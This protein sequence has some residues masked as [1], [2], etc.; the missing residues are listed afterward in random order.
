MSS[1]DYIRIFAEDSKE[2]LSN[3]T[4]AA[5]KSFLNKFKKWFT[6]TVGKEFSPQNINSKHIQEY[7]SRT[8]ET[9]E[10]PQ[11]AQRTLSAL[12]A[13][14][15]WAL[16]KGYVSRNPT[17]DIKNIHRKKNTPQWLTKEELA[18][19]QCALETKTADSL[20]NRVLITLI[21]NT[22][23]RISEAVE[24]KISDVVIEKNN[25]RLLVRRKDGKISRE[26]PLNRTAEKSLTKYLDQEKQKKQ[27]DDYLFSSWESE[28]LSIRGAQ[29][30]IKRFGEEAGIKNLNTSVLRHTFGHRLAESGAGVLAIALLMDYKTEDGQPNINSVLQYLPPSRDLLK[31]AKGKMKEAVEKL[32]VNKITNTLSITLDRNDT[33]V[34][35]YLLRRPS[36]NKV[37]TIAG[38]KADL[39]YDKD[40]NWAGIELKKEDWCGNSVEFPFL[41]PD[42]NDNCSV[43]K[44]KNALKI[45][46]TDESQVQKIRK[47]FCNI[48]YN[49]S[50]IF[51]IEFVL[52]SPVGGLNF[53]KNYV[54]FLENNY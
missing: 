14:F 36:V 1:N 48:D 3:N 10:P 41:N 2:N 51:G 42:I 30:A 33:L 25:S 37:K 44:S 11:T 29:H 22:G 7:C 23:L 39:L 38:V 52:N 43:V 35:V 9:G 40:G 32:I 4:I 13:F 50:G 8:Q 26:I 12:R 19:L 54:E 49:N 46:F 5:Y 28:K 53:I 27:A 34:Y 45:F 20:R 15:N 21:L 31:E 18:Q 16:D 24:L 47:E 17:M 6:Q